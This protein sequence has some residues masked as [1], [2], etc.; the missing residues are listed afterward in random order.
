MIT[1]HVAF[2]QRRMALR[3]CMLRWG[4]P[5]RISLRTPRLC[6]LLSDRSAGDVAMDQ[7][8]SQTVL[9]A[10]A[11][12]LTAGIE[13]GY[14]RALHVEHLT[15][16]VDPQAAIGVVPDRADCRGIER[17]LVDLVHRGVSAA[18]EIR[19]GAL[20]HVGVPF[21]HRLL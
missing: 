13:A 16:A 4:E 9:V 14:S 20:V 17:R 11:A 2:R 5:H 19:I 10:A 18:T 21:A 6:P 15:L 7:R 3:R 12:G 8:P 1:L